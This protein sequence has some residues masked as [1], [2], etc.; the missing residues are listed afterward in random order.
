MELKAKQLVQNIGYVGAGT[1]EYL[2]NAANDDYF[3]LELNPRLQVEHPCTEGV[4]GVN[5]PATQLQVAMGIPLPK[6]PEV[7]RLYGIDESDTSTVLDLDDPNT[8][9]RPIQKHVLAA[10]IT[11]ENPDESFKPTSGKVER[12][13]FQSTPAVWGYFSVGANGGVH[14]FADSQFGHL[15]ATGEDREAARKAL[16]LALKELKVRGEIRNPVEYLVQLLETDDFKSNNIDTSWLDGILAAKSINTH[17]DD[18]V[19]VASAALFR[20]HE[21]CKAARSEFE[22]ALER[23]QFS[24]AALDA[25]DTFDLDIVV[26]DVKYTVTV[27]RTGDA[28]FDLVTNGGPALSASVREQP[29]GTLL[30]SYGGIS[31]QLTG[32]EEPLGL[33][34]IVDG[35]TVFVPAAFD[36]SEIRSDVT[37]KIVRWLKEDGESVEKGETFA[38][39]EAMKMIMPLKAADA[40]TVSP[41]MAAGSVIEAGD[42][43]AG[44]ELDDPSKARSITPFQGDSLGLEEASAVKQDALLTYRSIFDQLSLA[45][46]GYDALGEDAVD[47]VG[48]LVEAIS[49]PDVFRLQVREVAGAIGQKMPAELD[50]ALAKVAASIDVAGLE[51]ELEAYANEPAVQSLRDLA[52]QWAGGA[53]GVAADAV[54]DLLDR[55]LAVE[56]KFVGRADEDAATRELIKASSKKDAADVLLAHGKLKARS[57]LAR[58]LVA[59]VPRVQALSGRATDEER[60]RLERDLD[61]VAALEAAGPGYATVSLAAGMARL[62]QNVPPFESRLSSLKND[63]SKASDLSTFA[64]NP[65]LGSYTRGVDLL[66]ELFD[67]PQVGQKAAEVYVRRMYSAHDILDISI[68]KKDDHLE[69][70][71]WYKFRNDDAAKAPL[72]FGKLVL[73]DDAASAVAGLSAT[74]E[75]F[76]DELRSGLETHASWVADASDETPVNTIHLLLKSNEATTD[77]KALVA[78]LEQ[79]LAGVQNAVEAARLRSVNFVATDAPYY[80][81]YFTF[82]NPTCIEFG[83]QPGPY[84]EDPLRRG[85]RP[86]FYHLLELGAVERNFLTMP[87]PTVNRDLRVYVGDD[88]AGRAKNPKFAA[89]SVFVRRLT[90][91]RDFF[92][93]GCARLLDK[94]LDALDMALLDARV[95]PT[96]S[97]R[98][99]VNV[100]PPVE[101]EDA[102]ELDSEFQKTLGG[103]LAA[104]A[105]RLLAARVDE[106]EVKFAF[107]TAGGVIPVRGVATSAEGPWLSLRTYIER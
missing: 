63:I 70:S 103:Y 34:I 78:T 48:R 9:Y 80:P 13:S 82:V 65:Q 58:A 98:V 51:S 107:K 4:T 25:L 79:A 62:R 73:F 29:D 17:V 105:T 5:L 61:R 87:L 53:A 95:K 15:F 86:T 26:S 47:A 67:D 71:W 64:S 89:Q 2:Y 75:G 60:A 99:Y 40:G 22:S 84:R 28:S 76:G 6:M 49:D 104:R 37:G 36:P 32:Q 83:A 57:A 12:V 81:R 93:G 90:H 97:G 94:A 42:L 66:T 102:K 54:A 27:K 72:R 14:E 16:V 39:V 68:T 8:K 23:G 59:A 41:K 10:R 18:S 46:D 44:L 7:R 24:T 45:M 52:A 43:L 56:E 1:V 85:M 31:H 101:F 19:V 50:A 106:I 91:S 77:D 92:E 30:A 33:R 55:F 88:R 11:A 69:A 74:V 100:I 35:A 20:A 3:F 38:E 96:A 21:A